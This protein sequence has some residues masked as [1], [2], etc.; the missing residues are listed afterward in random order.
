LAALHLPGIPFAATLGST[1]SVYGDAQIR[2]GGKTVLREHFRCV[3]EI[4]RFSDQ[5]CYA[6]S[7]SPL[8][9]LRNYKPER[10]EPIVTRLVRE[11]SKRARP[12]TR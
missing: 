4:I 5:L 7:G 6:P 2:F 10:L 3:P 11:G 12:A 9:P 1:G 8:I